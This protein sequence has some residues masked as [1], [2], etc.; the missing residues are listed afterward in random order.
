MYDLVVLGGGAGGLNVASAAARVGATVALVE[1]GR[2]GGECTHTGCVPSKALI[3]AAQVAHDARQAARYGIRTG[4]VTVDFPAVMAAVRERIAHFARHDSAEVLRERGIEVFHGTAAFESHDTVV[5]NDGTRLVGGRFVVAT[6]SRPAIPGIP[7]LAASDSLDNESFWG[8]PALPASL[9][10]LGGGPVGVELGQA[11]ARLGAKVTIVEAADRLLG[12]EDPAVGAVLRDAL[13]AEGVAVLTSARVAGVERRAGQVHL[14]AESPTGRHALAADAL[15]VATGRRANVEGLGLER[16]N[17]R[18]TPEAGIEVDE[19]LCTR[20]PRVYALGDVLGHHQWTHA[21]EREAGVVFQNAVLKLARKIRYDAVPRVVYTDPEVAAVGQLAAEARAGRDDVQVYR[22]ELSG[23]DRAVID[24]R[25]RGF[26][27]VVAAGNGRIL[28]ATFVGPEAS[29]VIGQLALAMERGL[30]MS[31]L[32]DVVQ[33]YPS[34]AA[35]LRLLSLQALGRR[36]DRG[37]FRDALRWVYGYNPREADA[38][39]PTEPT[40]HSLAGMVHS[41]SDSP[42]S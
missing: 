38:P 2:L 14:V 9:L 11:M 31:D 41:G 7:G 4:P 24:G 27:E 1:K 19:Y 15:L 35:A 42:L 32:A 28:G 17:V 10:V 8:L 40:V 29:A 13:E 23:V 36:L 6:G 22:V 5:L 18:A 21:A 20:S 30:R 25:T 34:Y 16:I 3:R 33:P 37:L 39:A 26:A 12:A